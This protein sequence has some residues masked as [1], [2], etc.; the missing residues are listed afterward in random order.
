MIFCLNK[1]RLIDKKKFAKQKKNNFN[2]YQNKIKIKFNTFNY[3]DHYL[4]V[5]FLLVL[6]RIF[7]NG[8][9]YD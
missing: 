6:L 3:V 2:F 4:F 1:K 5:F 7:R 9:F 8:I